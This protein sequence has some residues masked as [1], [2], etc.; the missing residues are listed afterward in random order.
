M[1]FG[2]PYALLTCGKSML[3]MTRPIKVPRV[4][5]LQASLS[6][7]NVLSA[8]GGIPAGRINTDRPVADLVDEAA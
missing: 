2:R 5:A 6:N 7:V 1:F 8:M 4:L 3:I